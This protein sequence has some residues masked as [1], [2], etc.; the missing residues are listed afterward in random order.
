MN[1][2]ND[3]ICLKILKFYVPMPGVTSRFKTKLES[4]VPTSFKKNYL[5]SHSSELI[6][7]IQL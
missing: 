3:D 2:L 1:L 5:L 4:F 6:I 7:E